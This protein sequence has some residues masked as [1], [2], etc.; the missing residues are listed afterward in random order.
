MN[1][2][3]K[4]NEIR[5]LLSRAWSLRPPP[6]F[7]MRPVQSTSPPLSPFPVLRD[8]VIDRTEVDGQWCRGLS[9][10]ASSASTVAW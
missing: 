6:Y 1:R 9:K 10:P 5:R 8:L 3:L 4:E 2:P 7:E